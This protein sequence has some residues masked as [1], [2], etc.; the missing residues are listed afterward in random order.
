MA[1][2]STWKGL[3]PLNGFSSAL[4][5]VRLLSLPWRAT[6]SNSG[7]PD[8]L[9]FVSAGQSTAVVLD[10]SHTFEAFYLNGTLLRLFE[11]DPEETSAG[12]LNLS[13]TIQS[14]AN[15][16]YDGEHWSTE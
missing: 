11:H 2:S 1:R 12:D 4:D 3:P 16:L 7:Y 14:P 10:G 9:P 5:S 6:F 8:A 13:H 15:F